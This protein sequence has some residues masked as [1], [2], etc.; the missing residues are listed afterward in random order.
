MS[1]LDFW[2]LLTGRRRVSFYDS[3]EVMRRAVE[4][5]DPMDLTSLSDEALWRIV[6]EEPRSIR[7]EA[8]HR[9][10]EW[11][12]RERRLSP[13]DGSRIVT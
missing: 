1:L 10:L 12:A 2:R 11:R 6:E 8:A 9:Q 13:P 7:A 4:E 3:Q 5:M